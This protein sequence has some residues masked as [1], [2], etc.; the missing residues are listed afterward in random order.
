MSFN[1]FPGEEEVLR[2]FQGACEL[3]RLSASGWGPRD[4]RGASCWLRWHIPE[5]DAFVKRHWRQCCHFSPCGTIMVCALPG[6]SL[7]CELTLIPGL[8]V[9]LFPKEC[10][11]PQA[12]ILLL[13]A[14]V[15][16]RLSLFWFILERKLPTMKNSSSWTLGVS[17]LFLRVC[18]MSIKKLPLKKHSVQ[19]N[20][21]YDKINIFEY[22]HCFKTIIF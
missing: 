21:F 6:F 10:H 12:R 14:G 9:T 13:S 7:G 20:I 4:Q 1:T 17:A 18:Y 11:L 16:S 22:V 19:W 15:F 2:H 5:R 3:S 8:A